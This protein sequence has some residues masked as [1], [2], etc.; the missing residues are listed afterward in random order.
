[1][2]SNVLERVKGEGISKSMKVSISGK[3][4]RPPSMMCW[5]VPDPAV[6]GSFAEASRTGRDN[7]PSLEN[8]KA[9]KEPSSTA[10]YVF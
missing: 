5:T 2:A 10:N 7:F 9:T 8:L 3:S 6:Q 1:M 4:V